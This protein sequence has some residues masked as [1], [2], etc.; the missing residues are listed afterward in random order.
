MRE[1]LAFDLNEI[2][3]EEDAESHKEIFDTPFIGQCFLSEEEAFLFL[4]SMTKDEWIFSSIW[5]V[6]NKKGNW[7]K[8]KDA[9]MRIKLKRI[10]EIFPEEWQVVQF[11][12]EHNHVLLST[13]E[14]R[15]LPSYR[16]ITT[17]D[18]KRILMLKEGGLSVRQL[19]RVMEL[20]RNVRHGE[21]SFLVKDVH[22]FLN[23]YHRMNSNNDARDLLEY[24]KQTKYENPNFQY[25]YT[26]DE[27]SR[28]EH[29]YWSH[30]HSFNLYQKY[31]DVVVFDTT[32]KVNTYDMPFGI[33]VGI[34]NHGRT[35]LLG[36][37][38]L[39]NETTKAFRWLFKNFSLLMG[40][41]PQTILTDQDPWMSEA[42]AQEMP[43][44]K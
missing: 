29:I 38:L 1:Q 18:E 33:F 36:C 17:E 43:T 35:I 21:L 3:V 11:V 7:S 16:C 28:L 31:G 41:P 4:Q 6:E 20:E 23:K 19:M 24:C 13:Q 37:A 40:K 15:F 44:T 42:I 32:Y 8:E 14:V 12:A 30:A 34:D 26:L 5:K 9:H 10:N 2:P 22:N 39:R 25:T 27:E